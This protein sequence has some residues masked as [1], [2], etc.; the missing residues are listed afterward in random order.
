MGTDIAEGYFFF[1]PSHFLKVQQES[2][3]KEIIL[4]DGKNMYWYI[5]DEKTAYRTTLGRELEIMS[6]LCTGMTD[7]KKDFD[8]SAIRD[9]NND[10]SILKL[11]PLM[12]WD[13]LDHLRVFIDPEKFFISRVE[14][15][16]IIG[17][18]TRFSL[19]EFRRRD[20]LSMD[21]FRFDVPEDVRIIVEE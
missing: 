15:I 10:I 6:S 17:S 3:A 20:D 11:T 2:P 9:E 13:E 14:I 18:I 5:P 4:S 19:K 21:F 7:I 16:N 8:V 12:D 1:M